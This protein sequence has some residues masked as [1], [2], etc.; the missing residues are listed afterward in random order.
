[1][2]RA[3]GWLV[4]AAAI[5]STALADSREH[6]NPIPPRLQWEA[7]GGYCGEVSLISAGLYF[8]QY[9]SQFDARRAAIGARPQRAGELLLGV[10]DR[11]AAR[12][13]RLVAVEWRGRGETRPAPFLRWVAR[14]VRSDRP[15]AIGVFNNERRLYGRTDP[16]AGD[17]TYDHIVPVLGVTRSPR[18][19]TRNTLLFSDNGLWGLP[20]RWPFLFTVRFG[21]FPATRAAANAPRA[22]IY[23]LPKGQRNYGI[24]IAGVIDRDGQT[25]P[26]RLATSRNR[27][28]PA[29]RRGSNRRPPARPLGITVTVS[30]LTPGTAYRLYRYNRLAA[31]PTGS[32]NA[33]AHRAA[34]VRDIIGPASRE[35][36]FRLVIRSDETLAYRCVPATAP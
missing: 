14:Q 10:N 9:L 6:R 1:M 36:N 27:E 2:I 35:I 5:A 30:G 22:P 8:G 20:G 26:V 21:A 17:P 16:A 4:L 24:A 12:R 15:V 11:V 31:I 33:L 28:T 25:V 7:N 18:G 3:K 19:F 32:F 13:M 34:E 23:A 29:I